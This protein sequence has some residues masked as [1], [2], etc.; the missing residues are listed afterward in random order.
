MNSNLD[1]ETKILCL[2]KNGIVEF[3]RFVRQVFDEFVAIDYSA[4]GNATFYEFIREEEIGKR[5]RQGNYFLVYEV[6]NR[7]VGILELRDKKH[8]CLLFVDK[9]Y[10]GRGIA[11]ELFKTTIAY[12]RENAP[13]IKIIEVNSSPYALE[14]YK[15]MG[16]IQK[17]NLKEQNGIKY[18]E[19]EYELR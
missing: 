7:I 10:Q 5:L 19:L 9:N 14:I 3:S 2:E 6:D 15:K 18:N 11:K 16:F 17:S 8:I 4:E 1:L 12:I 13:T